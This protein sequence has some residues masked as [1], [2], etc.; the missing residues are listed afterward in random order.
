MTK[1]TIEQE[2]IFNKTYDWCAS[3]ITKQNRILPINTMWD[4]YPF[5]K[6]GMTKDGLTVMLSKMEDYLLGNP[7]LTFETV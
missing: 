3:V 6:N 7:L 4:A 1:L 5:K 2:N